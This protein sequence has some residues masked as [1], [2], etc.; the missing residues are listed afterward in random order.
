MRRIRLYAYYGEGGRRYG[1][2]RYA[3]HNGE[4]IAYRKVWGLKPG[5]KYFFWFFCG[6]PKS[7]SIHQGRGKLSKQKWFYVTPI[8]TAEER[9]GIRAEFGKFL[10]APFVFLEPN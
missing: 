5:R 1:E 10:H 2:M 7:K 6:K 3:E 4:I 9:N 8:P